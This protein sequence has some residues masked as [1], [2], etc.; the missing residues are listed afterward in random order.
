MGGKGGDK[1][2][3]STGS[4]ESQGKENANIK[5]IQEQLSKLNSAFT[6]M[7]TF[8]NDQITNINKLISDNLETQNKKIKSLEDRA[9]ALEKDLAD[10][11]SINKKLESKITELSEKLD[12]NISHSRRLNLIIN[13]V[14]ENKGEITSDVVKD[15][16]I[17]EMK[18]SAES[19][20][21]FIFR[22]LH[23]LGPIDSNKDS[24]IM[25][26]KKDKSGKNKFRSIIVAFILM[27][28]RNLV[29][30][31]AKFLKGTSYSIKPDLSPDLA[32]LR[33]K[34]LKIRMD[35]KSIDTSK[36]AQLTYHSFRPVLLI[37]INGQTVKYTD[38]VNIEDCE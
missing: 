18:I 26:R 5:K 29:L 4:T 12:D 11:K 9:T 22:D 21:S 33:N 24:P 30:T 19:V 13:D 10:Q 28:H 32:K 17:N 8:V 34:L 27:E 36:F 3:N 14:P 7:N 15:F 6:K 1:S 31:H 2:E 35:I 16:F 23:R 20:D 38:N 37:R 25:F